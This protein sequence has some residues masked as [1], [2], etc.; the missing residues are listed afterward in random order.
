METRR[1]KICAAGARPLWDEKFKIFYFH[2]S[3][4]QYIFID[5]KEIVSP[6]KEIALYKQHNNTLEN[7]GYVNM[8]EAFISKTILPY[9]E[10]IKRVLDFGC[11][12]GPVLAELLKRRGFEVDIYDPY[13]YPETICEQKSYD[14][15]TATEVFEHLKDPLE[16][17][18]LLRDHLNPCGI[19]AV[20]TLFHPGE[21]SAFKNWW[22]RHDPTHISF[23]QP[24]TF[25]VLADRLGFRVLM[26]DSKNL[27][28]ME[29]AGK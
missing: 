25:E 23:F 1:C 14:L 22:Y 9:Q 3:R 18:R 11:G 4:C 6:E 29:R 12:P 27:C 2:C 20:M 7:E 26:I 17:A 15:I 19:L 5:E 24:Q 16:T 13:F 28:V 10:R 8:F 21:A